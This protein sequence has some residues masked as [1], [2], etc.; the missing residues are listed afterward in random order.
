MKTDI[1]YIIHLMKKF[2]PKGDKGE[3]GEQD[4]IGAAASSGGG[5]KPVYPTVT[6][7]SSGRKFGPTHNPEQKVW[8]TGLTRG[9]SNTLL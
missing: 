9:K 6:K 1:D 5:S 2:T 4:D 7:W 3:M 8:S